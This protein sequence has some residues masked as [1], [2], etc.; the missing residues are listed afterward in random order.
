MLQ[1]IVLGLVPGTHLQ[2]TLGWLVTLVLGVFAVRYIRRNQK[3]IQ[4]FL[5]T[6]ISLRHKKTSSKPSA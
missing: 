2:I 5:N 3:Q 6:P 4:T 1:F